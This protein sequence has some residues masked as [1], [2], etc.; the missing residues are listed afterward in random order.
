MFVSF[1]YIEEKRGRIITMDRKFLGMHKGI[2]HFTLGKR[3][4]SLAISHLGYYVA[5]IDTDTND[6]IVVIFL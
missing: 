5:K 3:L 6:I 4:R 1:Q 2:H